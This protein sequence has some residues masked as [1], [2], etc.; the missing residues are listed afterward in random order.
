MK[1]PFACNARQGS[2]AR[3]CL[4]PVAASAAG[5]AAPQCSSPLPVQARAVAMA[6]G[7]WQAVVIMLAAIAKRFN[8]PLE[9]EVCGVLKVGEVYACGGC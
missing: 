4:Q 2:S 3:R 7:M 6:V 9:P 8:Q 1:R 5:T